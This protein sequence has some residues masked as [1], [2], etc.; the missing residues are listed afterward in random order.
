LQIIENNSVIK[1]TLQIKTPNINT[2]ESGNIKSQ[3]VLGSVM[4]P[5][6]EQLTKGKY[7]SKISLVSGRTSQKTDTIEDTDV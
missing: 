2:K 4:E 5:L 1:T 6:I 7:V 3:T